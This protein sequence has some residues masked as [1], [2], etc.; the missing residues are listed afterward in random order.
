MQL[1][2]TLK[3]TADILGCSKVTV[4]EMV[5]K[6]KLHAFITSQQFGYR[7]PFFALEALG[8]PPSTL[9]RL[10]TR[11]QKE[12]ADSYRERYDAANLGEHSFKKG[13]LSALRSSH[14]KPFR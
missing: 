10:M 13:R 4:R 6:G 3:Q 9:D 11:A 14:I 5:K 1:S 12:R 7:I 8:I 2:L